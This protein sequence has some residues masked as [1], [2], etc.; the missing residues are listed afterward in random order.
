MVAR[1]LQ[2]YCGAMDVV[3]LR[4]E[5]R[6]T[7]DFLRGDTDIVCF[8]VNWEFNQE[9]VRSQIDSVPPG[10]L[11]VAGGR[12]VTESPE[13]WMRDCG[14]IDILVRGDGEETIAEIAEGKDPGEIAG[15]SWRKNGTVVHNKNRRCGRM[16]DD[17]Y[18][19]RK[20]RKYRYTVDIRGF[21]TGWTMDSIASSRGCP[22]NCKFCSFNRN[23]WGEKRDWTG[24][25]VESVVRELEEIEAG[26]VIFMDDVFTA[27]MDRVEAICDE[28]IRRGIRKRYFAN[29][30][31]EAAKRMDVVR[32]MERA[33]FAMLMLGVESTQDRTLRA[34][35]K[36]YDTA[37]VQEYMGALRTTRIVLHAYFML[38]LLGETEEEMLG[39]GRFARQ[40]G[41]DT[42]A[43]SRLRTAK[44]DGLQ[45][46]IAQTPGYHIA[47]DGGVFS[48]AIDRKRMS[49]LRRQIYREF[50][51]PRHVMKVAWKCVRSGALT[52]G[53]LAKF[54]VVAM[55]AA[56]AR[57]K[58][59]T[60]KKLRRARL[61]YSRPL[62]DKA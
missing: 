24:R 5:S 35:N 38:G 43:L 49:Q 25:S 58:E 61:P 3:D 53:M 13:E 17:V 12:R 16:K 59:R 10:K 8:S 18:P 29:A 50:Y 46:L 51:T 52:P 21:D 27:D 11:V 1:V 2:R 56:R 39:I 19:D 55:R 31:L 42:L 60:A 37:K 36:G 4:H 47:Q 45:E 22:Y 23:P 30:R 33:G 20:L 57:R 41:A 40:M 6:Q 9:F 28:I 32:K 62:G 54:A 15:I 44:Y 34:M 48:D 26:I 7:R 14:R